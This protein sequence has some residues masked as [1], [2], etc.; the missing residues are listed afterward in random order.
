MKRSTLVCLALMFI[1]A[2]ALAQLHPVLER[3]FAPD[4][5]YRVGDVDSVNPF[6]GNLIVSLPLGPT[7]PVGGDLKYGLTL[8]Y[9][10]MLW[11]YY[12]A[13]DDT[14][15]LC[16]SKGPEAPIDPPGENDCVNLV[17]EPTPLTNAGLGWRLSLGDLL[18]QGQPGNTVP[19]WLYVAPDG[20]SSQAL[21]IG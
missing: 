8:T 3:G 15:P 9:N 4:K 6:N 14:H 18:A 5:I 11:D 20:S 7:Y 1:A 12:M 17:A 10:S 2:P 19:T 21:Q 16:D 13:P